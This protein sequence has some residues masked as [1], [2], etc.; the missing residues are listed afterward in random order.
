MVGLRTRGVGCHRFSERSSWP[1]CHI[2]VYVCSR[3]CLLS[4]SD[5]SPVTESEGWWELAATL[6]GVLIMVCGLGWRVSRRRRRRRE[7][8]DDTSIYR[9]WQRCV[10]TRCA[11]VPG[12]PRHRLGP[13]RLPRRTDDPRWILPRTDALGRHP[14]ISRSLGAGASRSD[15]ADRP[16]SPR[17]PCSSRAFWSAG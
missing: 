1:R 9:P 11:S 16:I 2:A 5:G 7:V 13:S 12:L 4:P 8:V 15:Y 6:A 17:W 10:G 3:I 14:G